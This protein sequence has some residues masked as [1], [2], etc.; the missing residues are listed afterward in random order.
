MIFI[1]QRHSTE[2]K[3]PNFPRPYMI[4]AR[5]SSSVFSSD[6]S[7]VSLLKSCK[8]LSEIS[9]IHGCM[10]KTGLD[11][12]H[13]SL[14][15]LLASSIAHTQYAASIFDS[16]RSPN[17]FMFNTIIR[18]HSIGDDPQ[19]ALTIFNDLR[20]RGISLDQFSSITT[21]KACT[22][23]QALAFG[24]GVHGIVLRSGQRS[25]VE[26]KNSLLHFYGVCGR[27]SDARQLFDEFPPEN[28][29]VSWNTLMGG[30]LTASKPSLAIELFRQMIWSGLRGS[31]TTMLNV[32]NASG[33]VGN[34][35]GVETIHGHYIKTGFSMKLNVATAL[36]DTYAKVGNI[37]AG[38]KIFNE[39]DQKDAAMWNC[40]IQR[41]ARC[42]LVEE[43]VE[44]LNLM[45]LKKVVPN[46]STFAGFLSACDASTASSIGKYIRKYV[47]EEEVCA[48]AVI[49]TALVDMYAKCG[50]LEKAAGIFNRMRDKDVKSWTAIISALGNHGQAGESLRLFCQMEKEGHKPNEV[51]FLAVLS[52]CSHGGLVMEAMNCFHK[53]VWEYGFS[54]KIEHYGCI[55]DVLGRAGM[56]EEAYDLIKNLPVKVDAT[57]W[58]ALLGACR[59]YGNVE[60]GE[61][62]KRALSDTY[63]QHPADAIL[64]S[65][66]YAAAG[67]LPKIATT[68]EPKGQEETVKE[69]GRSNIEV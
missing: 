56:L 31:A 10:V 29:L 14:S 13:F 41:Y 49:G 36:I 63:R 33:D 17:L 67:R 20:T 59:V 19:R 54:P 25:F 46:S 16:T 60:L 21:L 40:L 64:L 68:E 66:T 35:L 39:M 11:R 65:S 18:G 3:D 38:R 61:D 52:A 26:V 51:T 8:A 53:M 24:R 37:H 69:A 55:V 47:D 1:G 45:K 4:N 32:L 6:Q 12:D 50:L 5:R 28:D 23:V 43:S 15:K 34:L 57:T 30:Y 44:L 7:L 42:G 48:D 27:I 62:V 22:R 58:R 9:Q 2:A